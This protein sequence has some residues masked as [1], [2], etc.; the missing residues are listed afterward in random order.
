MCLCQHVVDRRPQVFEGFSTLGTNSV[1]TFKVACNSS[2]SYHSFISDLQ[3]VVVIRHHLVP[4][5]KKC[6]TYCKYLQQAMVEITQRMLNILHITND[7]LP[8]RQEHEKTLH[9]DAEDIKEPTPTTSAGCGSLSALPEDLRY[10][11]SDA[12]QE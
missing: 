4:S 9:E 8:E 7:D 11:V 10:M 1:L 5:S 3:P 6:Q 12:S 2:F